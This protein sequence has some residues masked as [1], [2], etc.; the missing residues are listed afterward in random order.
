MEHQQMSTGAIKIEKL[1]EQKHSK[2]PSAHG[3]STYTA[4]DRVVLFI[5]IIINICISLIM[6]LV[7]Q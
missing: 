5:I 3:E 6:A 1:S 7:R 2:K 4:E